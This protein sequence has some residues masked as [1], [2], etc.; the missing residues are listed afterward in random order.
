MKHLHKFYNKEPIPW[1]NLVWE[2]YFLDGNLSLNT[3][4]LSPWW[5]MILSLSNSFKSIAR[6]S[7]GEGSTVL[8]WKD[9][10]TSQPLNILL[11]QLCSF[12]KDQNITLKGFRLLRSWQEHFHLPLLEQAITQL[13]NP[14]LIN[15]SLVDYGHEKDKWTFIGESPFFSVK[16]TYKILLE[17]CSTHPIIKWL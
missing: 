2:N 12:S 16:R 15:E 8:L 5:K 4:R 3:S 14:L 13:Q 9:L 1:I 6:V 17:D 7:P 10:W 11:H